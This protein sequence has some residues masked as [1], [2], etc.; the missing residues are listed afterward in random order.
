ML[1]KL[2]FS[3]LNFCGGICSEIVAINVTKTSALSAIMY[4]PYFGFLADQEVKLSE[5]THTHKP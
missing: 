2:D 5:G 3:E 4:L 1:E